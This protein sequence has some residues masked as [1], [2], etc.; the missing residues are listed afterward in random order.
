MALSSGTRSLL[1]EITSWAVAAAL[2]VASAFYYSDI[3]TAAFAVFGVP[4]GE[5]GETEIAS[6]TPPPELSDKM[7]NKG[8]GVVE[9]RAGDSG[10]Y[11]AEVEVNGEAVEVLVDTGATLLALTHEDAERAGIYLKDSDYTLRARTANGIARIAPVRLSEV[12]I[13][14]I[15]VRDVEATVSEPGK[16]TT[17]L[18]GMSFLSRLERFEIRQGVLVLQN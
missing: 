8:G 10:H 9:I 17:T 3:K 6:E 7:S 13:G 12:T 1:S 2:I 14:D 15:R 11:N 4:L 18:L 16:L 5:S